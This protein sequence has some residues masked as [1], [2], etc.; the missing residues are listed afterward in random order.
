MIP[1]RSKPDDSTPR[2]SYYAYCSLVK[3]KLPPFQ[4]DPVRSLLG[5]QPESFM[6]LDDTM[7]KHSNSPFEDDPLDKTYEE[8][9]EEEDMQLEMGRNSQFQKRPLVNTN[10][11]FDLFDATGDGSRSHSSSSSSEAFIDDR[12]NSSASSSD[13]EDLRHLF[14]GSASVRDLSDL[15]IPLYPGATTT[16][17]D[18]IFRVLDYSIKT[19]S[20]QSQVEQ[21][22]SMMKHLLPQP[23]EVPSYY[24]Y[25]EI[26]LA[27]SFR[28]CSDF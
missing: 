27:H 17:L 10:D 5:S 9:E 28:V 22:L 16:Q 26:I 3:K 1:A 25:K 6:T 14:S 13:D 4:P 18:L 7:K 8:E 24:Q 21:L 23:N 19:K 12:A 2:S 11:A 15:K 20:S